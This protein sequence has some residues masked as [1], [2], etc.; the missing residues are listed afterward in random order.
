[1]SRAKGSSR[2][3]DISTDAL[4]FKSMCT[5]WAGYQPGLNYLAVTHVR[6]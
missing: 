3:L 2:S 6:K 4:I 1:M 5:S